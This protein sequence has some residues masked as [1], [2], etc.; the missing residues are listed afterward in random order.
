MLDEFKLLRWERNGR[1]RIAHQIFCK[2]PGWTCTSLNAPSDASTLVSRKNSSTL[3]FMKLF[4]SCF[5]S[6][7]WVIDFDLFLSISVSSTFWSETYNELS[8]RYSSRIFSVSDQSLNVNVMV[9]IG[10]S[11][12]RGCRYNFHFFS[13]LSSKHCQDSTNFSAESRIFQMLQKSR[14]NEATLGPP[15]SIQT[16][17]LSRSLVVWKSLLHDNIQKQINWFRNLVHVLV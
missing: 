12:H 16:R 11:S 14:N 5:I 7:N 10:F 8:G 1:H 15:P 9:R 17:Y 3:S 13:H 4:E 6:W 2:T